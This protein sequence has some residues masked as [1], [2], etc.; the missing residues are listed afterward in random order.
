MSRSG[1]SDDLEPN[2]LNVWRGAVAS[3][4]RGKRGQAM[5]KEMLAALDA[6]PEKALIAHELQNANG[7]HCALGVV[8]KNR[9][10]A[11]DSI[12]PDEYEIVAREF[13]IASALAQEIMFMNDEYISD[14]QY[15]EVEICGP[16]RLGYPDYSRHS[17]TVRT[18]NED[19]AA[20]R[21]AHMR[22]WVAENISD[23]DKK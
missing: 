9:G 23:A 10:M 2:Q 8:G 16:M 20:K 3:A 12:D 15:I 17:Q 19:I 1:Y 21:W 7:D 5:L 11:L 4:I 6:M 18:T 13:G 14:F 22:N